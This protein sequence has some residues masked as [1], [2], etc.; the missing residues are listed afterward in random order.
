MN[1]KKF[2]EEHNSIITR[3]GFNIFLITIILL[4]L[5]Q[6]SILNVNLI[7]NLNW[8]SFVGISSGTFSFIL[9]Q[10]KLDYKKKNLYKEIVKYLFLFFLLLITINSLEFKFLGP[11]T[12]FYNSNQVLFLYLI[13]IVLGVIMFWQNRSVIRD[14]EQEKTREGK[15]EIKRKK[16]FPEKFSNINKIPVFRSIVKWV[17]KEKWWY[18]LGLFFIIVLFIY[19]RYPYMDLNFTGYHEMKYSWS[20]EPAKHMLDHGMLWNERKYIADPVLL[21]DGTYDTFGTYPL[22]EWGLYTT[23]K[24]FPNNS[25]ELNARLFTTFIG[26]LIFIFAYLLFKSFLSKKQT[27]ILLFLFSI[28][29]IIQFFTYVTVNDSLIILCFFISLYFLIKGL[30]ENNI[31]SIFFAGII[32]G[33]GINLKYSLIIFL[34]PI[35]LILI[36][37]YKKVSIACRFNYLLFFLPNLILQT[38]IFRIS[39]RYLPTNFLLYLSIFISLVV[40]QIIFYL[41][42]KKV[43][44]YC[45]KFIEKHLDSKKFYLFIIIGILII[46]ITL[47]KIEWLGE[48]F[49]GSITDQYL[50]FNWTMYNTFFENYRDWLTEPIYYLSLIGIFGVIISKIRKIRLLF[51]GFLISALTYLILASK[52]IYFHEYYNHIIII[53][54]ILLASNFV[55]LSCKSLDKFHLKIIFLILFLGL[56]LPPSID[57]IEEMLSKQGEYIIDVANYLNIHMK[58]DEFFLGNVRTTISFYADRKM[59]KENDQFETNEILYQNFRKELLLGS[60]MDE[61]MK[62]YKTKYYITQG[63]DNF[64]KRAFYHLYN[65]DIRRDDI[66]L[67]FRTRKILCKEQ[68]ICYEEQYEKEIEKLFQEKVQPYLTLEKQ[69]RYYYIYRFY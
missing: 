68:Y 45:E 40:L 65:P 24:L 35:S 30:R 63:K 42:I 53:A 29:V 3:L 11:F 21:I 66:K 52:I 59:W 34:V 58:E 16:E 56:I 57:N 39:I 4:L 26:I 48:M 28:N 69:I 47:I 2:I 1:F 9:W 50:I 27:L 13:T 37:Y 15:E 54:F 49:K 12:N 25:I 61:L 51:L 38:V 62:K 32:A 7:L 6:L 17:Y 8:L 10:E 67:S 64:N 46:I 41:N 44:Y 43:S 36:C 22:M 19:I 20:V 23:F 31:E 60:N 55:Y 14:L 18:I 33:I 5:D